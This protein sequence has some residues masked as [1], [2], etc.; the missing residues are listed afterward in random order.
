MIIIGNIGK[1]PEMKKTQGGREFFAFTVAESYGKE[2]N[3]TTN[4]FGISFFGK[5]DDMAGFTKGSRVEI[6]G[7][8]KVKVKDGKAYLDV[9]TSRIKDAPLPPKAEKAPG[10]EGEKI[11][12]NPAGAA[13]PEPTGVPDRFADLDDDIPF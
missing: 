7:D 8:L 4:W 13:T 6:Q 2:D 11:A 5:A 10:T 9:L 3:R 12:S 1:D